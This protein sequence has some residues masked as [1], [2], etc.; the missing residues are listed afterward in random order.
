[1]IFCDILRWLEALWMP[2]TNEK[3]CA[4]SAINILMLSAC[5]DIIN[6]YKI[7]VYIL[8]S[9]LNLL[10]F[11]FLYLKICCWLKCFRIRHAQWHRSSIVKILASFRWSS[12]LI[13]AYRLAKQA[14]ILM[15]WIQKAYIHREPE[16]QTQSLCNFSVENNHI[17]PMVCHLTEVKRQKKAWPVKNSTL[18]VC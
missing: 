1:M 13:L 2:V 17:Q 12:R 10:S 5:V 4:R 11:L 14:N 7:V 6:P 8:I 15:H 18:Y 16:L 9:H 3:C